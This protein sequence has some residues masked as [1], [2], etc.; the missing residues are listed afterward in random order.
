VSD[1]FSIL[2]GTCFIIFVTIRSSRTASG[3]AQAARIFDRF[4]AQVLPF[5]RPRSIHFVEPRSPL[6]KLLKAD[7]LAQLKR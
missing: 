6:R 4:E 2:A 3:S 1:G 7:L 5:E